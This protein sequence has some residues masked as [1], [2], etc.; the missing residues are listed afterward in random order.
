MSRRPRHVTGKATPDPY[1]LDSGLRAEEVERFFNTIWI[2]YAPQRLVMNQIRRYMRANA[3]K[4]GVPLGG[5]RLSQFSQAG[6]SALIE[7]MKVELAEEDLEAGRE[8]NPYRL[9]HI[10]IDKRITLRMFFQRLL[11]M[12]GDEFHDEPSDKTLRAVDRMAK[13]VRSISR[14]NATMLEE[15]IG[16]WVRRLGVEVIVVDEVQRLK[17][18]SEDAHDVTEKL[19]AFVDRGVVPIVLIGDEESLE[20]FQA[21]KQFSARLGR[22]LELKPINEGKVAELKLFKDFCVAFEE[23]FLENGV[24]AVRPGLGDDDI[25]DGLLAASSGH[26]GRVARLLEVAAIAAAERSAATI[27]RF[28]LFNAVEEFAIPNDWIDHNPFERPI[29]RRAEG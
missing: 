23:Q 25:L 7:R 22:P 29:R 17:R 10:T 9:V 26:V 8:V 11:A 18:V 20:F 1:D 13:N 27:D 28:D 16:Q 4:H 21:N 5:R 14:D 2:D 3:G 19:Q 12:L 24:F 15:R 6:K